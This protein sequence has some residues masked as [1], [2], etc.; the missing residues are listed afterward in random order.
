SAR[1][2]AGPTQPGRRGG[3]CR[4]G[5]LSARSR[6]GCDSFRPPSAAIVLPALPCDQCFRPG[7]AAVG[8]GR[9][10]GPAPRFGGRLAGR[11]GP[12]MESG[13]AARSEKRRVVMK[14]QA[15]QIEYFATTVDDK[16]GIG[17]DL[18]KRLAKEGVNLLAMLAFPSEAGK[19]QVDLVPENPDAFAK[20]A[21]RV[22]L[23]IGEP[24][25]AFLI[26]GTHRAGA[27]AHVLDRLGSAR[28]NVR[29]SSRVPPGRDPARAPA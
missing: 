13:M 7:R 23:A 26:Q 22:G 18:G 19:T 15:L 8:D 16:P 27:L 11:E 29:G 6:R 28:L 12:R 4:A 21:R 24:K 5:S 10:D 9:R 1:W 17:A 25:M 20:I 3:P 14:D 2:G